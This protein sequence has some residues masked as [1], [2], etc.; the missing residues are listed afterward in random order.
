[1]KLAYL[2]FDYL[3]SN[4]YLTFDKLESLTLD[5]NLQ[6]CTSETIRGK[7]KTFNA[8]LKPKTISITGE[9]DDFHS[10][11]NNVKLP[12]S[13]FGDIEN[14]EDAEEKNKKREAILTWYR[15][16][17]NLSGRAKSDTLNKLFTS[18]V[19]ETIL[20]NIATFFKIYEDFVLINFNLSYT[21]NS[22]IKVELSFKEMLLRETGDELENYLTY[23]NLAE[24]YN[25]EQEIKEIEDMF[26]NYRGF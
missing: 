14:E 19:N 17:N 3:G 10:L 25:A 6:V 21:S 4:V 2:N 18:M 5:E 1:M 7:N 8:Y 22:T 11:I 15:N 20:I 12:A 26:A 23:K 16:L 24:E 13:V 9:F